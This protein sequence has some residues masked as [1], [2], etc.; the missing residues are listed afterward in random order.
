MWGFTYAYIQV[1]CINKFP[2]CLSYL[3]RCTLVIR[4]L[5]LQQIV[6][7]CPARLGAS[8]CIFAEQ[9]LVVPRNTRL[10]S[11]SGR[12][13][14]YLPFWPICSSI[15]I[16]TLALH[17]RNS[18]AAGCITASLMGCVSH[19]NSHPELVGAE[20]GGRCVCSQSSLMC[21]GLE[22]CWS[23]WMAR[24]GFEWQPEIS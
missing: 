15:H 3:A 14:T 7:V 8:L 19:P 5:C 4:A 6:P 9:D 10:C 2:L 11:G 22:K 18:M 1:W 17:T 24:D 21:F 20:K 13:A 23:S 12:T 16:L